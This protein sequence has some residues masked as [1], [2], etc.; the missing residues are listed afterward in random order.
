MRDGYDV[1]VLFKNNGVV[2]TKMNN[3]RDRFSPDKT[4]NGAKADTITDVDFEEYDGSVYDDSTSSEVNDY[5][6][7]R[8][9]ILVC[10]IDDE[11]FYDAHC[12][13]I[14]KNFMTRQN[15][16]SIQIIFPVL[17]KNI[18]IKDFDK[19]KEII[20]N[21]AKLLGFYYLLTDENGNQ[22]SDYQ[23]ELDELHRDLNSSIE[24]KRAENAGSTIYL[25]QNTNVHSILAID[26]KKKYIKP[27][28]ETGKLKDAQDSLKICIWEKLKG[29][30]D[31]STLSQ[32]QDVVTIDFG[33]MIRKK[34]NNL[35][36]AITPKQ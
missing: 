34:E 2:R 13:Q 8:S 25:T 35:L 30:Y 15:D 22:E 7:S 1:F 12:R 19:E 5:K 31:C 21:D 26:L 18:S 28:E 9:L 10:F 20:Y 36:K 17:I 27:F 6:S 3:L 14:W 11:F 4:E 29:F 33:T 32:E 16:S 24:Q 23:S